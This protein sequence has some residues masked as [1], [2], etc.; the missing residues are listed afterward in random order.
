MKTEST[1]FWS[2][3]W[4]WL[5]LAGVV[6]AVLS[7]LSTGLGVVGREEGGEEKTLALLWLVV[8]LCSTAATGSPS[9]DV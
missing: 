2:G 1:D 3:E 4:R 8:L 5:E 6:A 9:Q 7:S